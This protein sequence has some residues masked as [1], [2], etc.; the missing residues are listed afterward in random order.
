MGFFSKIKNG[1]KKTK[2]AFITKLN[3]VFRGGDIDNDFYDELEFALVSSDMGVETTE[4]IISN[5]KNRLREKHIVKQEQAREELKAI[6]KEILLETKCQQF[7]YPLIIT[8]VGVNGVGKTTTIGKLANFFKKQGKSVSLVAGDTFRAA[9]TEQ[10]VEWANRAG[11]KII[12][13]SEGA[14]PSAVVYD[15]IAS[16]KAKKTDVLIVDTAG[17]LHT[18]VNLME[19]LKKIAR[20]E[21]REFSEAMKLNFIVL[22]AT[23][24][25][26]SLVQVQ[27]FKDAVGI[28]GI[29][30]TKLDGTSRGGIV[31]P[32][33]EEIKVPVYFVGLGEGMDDLEIFD[34]TSFVDGILE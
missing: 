6:L 2:D 31:F 34:P 1:L 7:E 24:G 23:I 18:K 8:V 28:D 25:Q 9:A 5:L 15:G 17:R 30:L 11:V 20:I 32:I 27:A 22:D 4:K 26:N 14:D 29:V 13:H 3:S 33:Q 12:K 19:E 21:N 10:L 16:A